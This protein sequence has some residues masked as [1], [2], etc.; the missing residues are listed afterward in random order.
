MSSA[1]RSIGRLPTVVGRW[2]DACVTC[3]SVLPGDLKV[4]H[5]LMGRSLALHS[6]TIRS[7][8][9][10][11]FFSLLAFSL[12]CLSSHRLRLRRL[13]SFLSRLFFRLLLCLWHVCFLFSG[14]LIY[15]PQDIPDLHIRA[16]GN[17]NLLQN[18]TSLCA[19]F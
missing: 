13:G 8:R 4:R 3:A 2:Y 17:F 11:F 16:L 15:N 9:R 5:V 1:W 7:R 10:F 19:H 18:S 12:R 6:L 14:F